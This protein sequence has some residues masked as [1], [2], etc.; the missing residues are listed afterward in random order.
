MKEW[1]GHP[2]P[3]RL[4]L[5]LRSPSSTRIAALPDIGCLA[6]R[7]GLERKRRLTQALRPGTEDNLPKR[8]QDYRYDK[9]GKI[10]EETEQ[11]HPREQVLAVHLPQADQHGGIE[12]P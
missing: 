2:K 8:Q 1:W 6:G 11:Q 7:L 3:S 10:I 4:L 5:P 9:R 12:Y